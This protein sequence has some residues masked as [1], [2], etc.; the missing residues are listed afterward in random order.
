MQ[1][2]LDIDPH[3]VQMDCMV[4]LH[5][6]SAHMDSQPHMQGGGSCTKMV[7]VLTFLALANS[8]F[9]ILP[10]TFF[11]SQLDLVKS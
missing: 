7:G 10:R 8:P 2:F 5:G 4:E 3:L 9:Q 11:L 1:V 6:Y